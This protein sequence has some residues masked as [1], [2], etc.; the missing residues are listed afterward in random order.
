MWPDYARPQSN[1]Q[2]AAVPGARER[3][4]SAVFG[5]LAL[6][7]GLAAVVAPF[8]PA[9]MTGF[10]QYAAVPFALTGIGLAVVGLT[11]RRA[12]KPLAVVGAAFSVLALAISL[13]MVAA[14][15]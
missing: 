8:V 11:G 15:R 3:V 7:V 2:W 14:F 6:L 12:G 1:A 4:G 9:D 5:A 10:R 13:Y